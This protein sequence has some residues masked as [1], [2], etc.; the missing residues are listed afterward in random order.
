MKKRLLFFLLT[1]A[2]ANLNSQ[3]YFDIEFAGL[4]EVAP[5]TVLVKN[6]TKGTH[7]SVHGSD[8][9]RLHV[10]ETSVKQITIENKKLSI[11]PNPMEHSCLVEFYNAQQGNVNI[12]LH[13]I[14]GK[15][16]YQISREFSQGKHKFQLSAVSTG[17]Y[18]LSVRTTSDYF[19]GHF[20]SRGQSGSKSNMISISEI[21]ANK[22]EQN[23]VN[24]NPNPTK[25]NIQASN[26]REFVIMDYTEGDKLSFTGYAD[27]YTRATKYISPKSSEILTFFLTE[28]VAV[29]NPATGMT[30]MDRNLGAK[31]VAISRNDID[32]FGDLYQWGRE[33]DGHEKRSSEVTQ[34]LSDSERPGHGLFISPNSPPYD[35]ITPQKNDFWHGVEGVNN[36]CPEGYRLPTPTELNIERASWSSANNAGAFASPLKL[37][38]GGYR[39]SMK[40]IYSPGN[41]GAYWSNTI[42]GTDAQFLFFKDTLSR[43]G[44]YGRSGGISVR[45]ISNN[46]SNSP[47]VIETGFVSQYSSTAADCGGN[48][49]YDGGLTVTERG[50]CWSINPN[51]T[52]DHSKTSDGVGT[53]VFTSA[54]TDL[55]PNTV[56]YLRAYA[57][58]SMGTGYGVQRAFLTKSTV[59]VSDV[60][61]PVTDKIWMDRNLGATRVATSS[62]DAYS[63][64]DLYQWGRGADGHE[65]RNS[66][67]TSTLSK[68]D[69]PGH[70]SFIVNAYND[71]WDW[72][73]PQNNNLWQGVNGV[74]NPCPEGYRLPT[75]AEWQDEHKSWQGWGAA[76]AFGSR[77]KLTMAGFRGGN[78]S[79]SYV[80]TLGNYWSSSVNGTEAQVLHFYSD[81]VTTTSANRGGGRSV[82]CL[83]ERQTV[84]ILASIETFPVSE[85]NSNSAKSGG[86]SISDG[87]SSIT[88]K[89]VCWSTSNNPTINDSKTSEGGATG[90]FISA[91]KG[92]TPN[93]TY[94]L[95]AYATNGVGTAYGEEISFLTPSG[96]FELGEVYNPTTDKTWLDR[97]LGAGRVATSSTDAAAYG[98]LYQWGRGTDGH[99]KRNSPLTPNLNLS[100]SD[101]PG[102]GMFI[103]NSMNSPFDWR[104]PQ[105]DDL[106]QGVN[107]VNNPCPAGFRL[108]TIAE[109]EAE[110]KSWS[111]DN[112]TGAFASQLKL[113]LGG[114]R[115]GTGSILYAGELGQYWSST[116]NGANTKV[117]HFTSINTLINSEYRAGG[118][119]VRC[120][121]D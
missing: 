71:P 53:G 8:I 118:R 41:D 21:S 28:I 95:R 88:D 19:T 47:P 55:A 92:L 6:L 111:S 27:G 76:G 43:M 29:F 81:G 37:T 15:V 38:A 114:F 62:T 93:T 101:T 48:V 34:F 20:V 26:N 33:T 45:C 63:Y 57:T 35:W 78:N 87:G 72:R 91:I 49:V 24:S 66:A 40:L 120:I 32:A 108:P 14:E 70:S 65:N 18:V 94:F 4:N 86:N 59:V 39:H 85:L 82:R 74:N 106:W 98:D 64:G 51:P 100:N 11:F 117:I 110:R 80:G 5:Q 112:A 44:K 50:I 56:Y 2:I 79:L 16:L 75:I 12:Q 36:P 23:I 96:L 25:R 22:T 31:R 30:W 102:H 77:L 10:T 121:K 115:G 7:V 42:D 89:G 1:F 52:V 17:M 9:L 46:I 97:N 83:K 58:N 67:T 107:G 13:S 3:T 68:N 113:T 60:Y 90:K 99:E 69:N 103:V 54:I 61:N 116:V 119:S 105:Q 84:S 109:L 104:S 73:S